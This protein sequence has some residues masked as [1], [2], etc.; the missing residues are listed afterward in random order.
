MDVTTL[1][2]RY[3]PSRGNYGIRLVIGGTKGTTEAY[4]SEDFTKEAY[5]TNYDMY[6]NTYAF[7][8]PYTQ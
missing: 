4:R 5:F 1:L 2:G 6:G 7:E 8:I 3:N